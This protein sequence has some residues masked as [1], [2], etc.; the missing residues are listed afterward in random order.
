MSY[1]AEPDAPFWSPSGRIPRSSYILRSLV[2]VALVVGV[3]LAAGGPGTESLTAW[4][5][6]LALSVLS[7]FQGLKRGRDA[8]WPWWLTLIA[9]VFLS[10]ITWVVLMVWPS[11]RE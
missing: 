6:I 11:K 10:G 5:V 9:S 4:L 1:S 7:L 2:I 8:G 3:L